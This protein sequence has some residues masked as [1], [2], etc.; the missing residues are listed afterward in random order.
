MEVLN[1]L[2]KLLPLTVAVVVLGLAGLAQAQTG[3][4]LPISRYEK[5]VRRTDVVIVT[6]SYPLPNLPGGGGFKA[7]AH[8]STALGKPQKIYGARI[9]ERL[10]D[11]DQLAIIQD[12][13]DR[14]IRAA[15]SSGSRPN[16]SSISYKS[17]FGISAN[18]YSYQVD[19]SD[20]PKWN[21]YLVAGSYTYQSP[22]IETLTRFRDVIGQ[23]RQKLIS[24][25]AR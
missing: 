20:K 14:M 1:M 15:R 9:A 24:L 21:L 17:P 18:Y 5:F 10:I 22:D 13:L 11:F 6:Q 23:A 19:G 2:K 12:G 7:F 25:G 16:T 4:Q 3:P 8:V